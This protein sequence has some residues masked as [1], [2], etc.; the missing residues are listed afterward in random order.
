MARQRL[1]EGDCWKQATDRLSAKDGCDL[2]SICLSST[3]FVFDGTYYKQMFGTVMDSLVS[4][5]V[6]NMVMEELETHGILP[7]PTQPHAC[8]Y[9]VDD[10]FVICPS[11]AVNTVNTGGH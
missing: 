9:Y 2:L 8:Y 5:V 1:I 10:T 4:A 11:T 7:F 6:P 3:Y